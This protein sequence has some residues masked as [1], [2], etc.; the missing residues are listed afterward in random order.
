LVVKI[1]YVSVDVKRDIL[2][3]V[4]FSP[5]GLYYLLDFPIYS[6]AAPL[7]AAH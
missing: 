4:N 1:A 7:L 2:F 5:I 6:D 3:L